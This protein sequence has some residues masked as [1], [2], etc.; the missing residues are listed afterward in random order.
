MLTITEMLRKKGVVDKFVEFFGDGLASLPLADR[1]TIANMAPEFGSTCGIFP[2]DE[3]TIR[4]LE[5]TGRSAEQIALV[6]AYAKAQGLWRTN[7]M[8]E[9]DYTDVLELDLATVE[10]SLAGPKRPQDRVPLRTAK[11]T[12]RKAHAKMAEERAQKNPGATGKGVVPAGSKSF[13]VADGAVLI[14]AITSCT[15]TSNPAV[16]VAAGLLARNARKH[17]LTSKPWVKTS[18]APGSRVVTDYLKAA[19]LLDDLE[20]VGFYVV[21]YGCTTCI[22]NSG[23]LRPEISDAVKAGDVI[24]TSVLSGNRNFEG[25]VHPEVKMNF[26]ASPPLVVAYA[27]AGTMDIDLNAEP[28]GTRQGR[29]AGLPEGH[30]AVAEGRAGSGRRLRHLGHVQAG[31]CQRVRR[32][33]EL[34]RH[35]GAAGRG[36]PV[37]GRLDLRSQPALFRG[38]DHDPR[39]RSP[40]F[41]ARACSRCSATRSPPTT[42]PRPVT[43]RRPARLRSTSWRRACSP[44]TS[45]PTARAA[46][47]TR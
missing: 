6:E 5:L 13:E 23:P 7:G 34:E 46:A 4:Y 17:G 40:T 43:S 11:D 3:E 42:S 14:A 21:G 44:W 47:T 29:Q 26:L 36:V 2:I 30:L 16:L 19:N 1:A 20:A 32:R 45:T 27:L 38:H 24:A 25:R 8:R 9:A 35:P 15:N 10:P 28:I 33:R 12:Y 18:L 31:L 41:A 37:G 39:A 22:G